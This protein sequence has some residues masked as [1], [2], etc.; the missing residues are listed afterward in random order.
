[1]V[2]RWCV[3]LIAPILNASVDRFRQVDHTTREYSSVGDEAMID[4][5][6][7]RLW[8]AHRA[9]CVGRWCVFAIDPYP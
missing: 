6:D 5:T 7:L 9:A 8:K 4:P 1:M 3:F 2:D